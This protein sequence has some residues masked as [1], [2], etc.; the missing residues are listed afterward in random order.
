MFSSQCWYSRALY[1]AFS[2]IL[3][4]F[5]RFQAAVLWSKHVSSC[6]EATVT[7]SMVYIHVNTIF[8]RNPDVESL[9]IQYFAVT[10]NFL[11]TLMSCCLNLHWVVLSSL[12]HRPRY[13]YKWIAYVLCTLGNLSL[14]IRHFPSIFFRSFISSPMFYCLNMHY[15]VVRHNPTVYGK[16]TRKY[17]VFCALWVFNRY[18]SGIFLHL[19]SALSLS[20]AECIL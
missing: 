7:L 18:I 6:F 1:S 8:L 5:S 9:Y 16:C 14:Y 17:L 11:S 20:Q 2:F 10:C 13:K 12:F 3:L 19:S 15:F 4:T